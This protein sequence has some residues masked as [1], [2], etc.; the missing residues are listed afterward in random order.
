MAGVS[1][2]GIYY[3]GRWYPDQAAVDAAV[4]GSKQVAA[5]KAGQTVYRAQPNTPLPAPSVENPNPGAAPAGIPA[6]GAMLPDVGGNATV[7]NFSSNPLVTSLETAGQQVS[8]QLTPGAAYDLQARQVGL[9]S[10]TQAE[11]EARRLGM[12]PQLMSAVG[13]TGIEPGVSGSPEPNDLAAEN[14]IYARA[15]DTAG[16][17][18]RAALRGLYDTMSER[19]FS[20]S[21]VEA[22]SVPGVVNAANAQLGDVNREQMIQSLSRARSVADRN[23]A[24]RLT[25]RGQNISARGQNLALVPALQSFLTARS[26]Y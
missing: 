25:Q 20:G 17:Q 26:L 7:P 24:G 12:L 1:R 16:L 14:A 5:T 3:N 10:S 8:G 15:K 21:P 11:A 18:S 22:A 19:G 2:G 23:Y 13:G 4:Y 6:R 9:A